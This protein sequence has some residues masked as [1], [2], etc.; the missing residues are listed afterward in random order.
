MGDELNRLIDQF[1][2]WIPKLLGAIFVLIIGWLIALVLK[3]ITTNALKRI[4]LNRRLKDL[5]S[6]HT[7]N[8][9]IPDPAAAVGGFIYWL[10]LIITITIMIGVLN[11]PVL[12]DLVN[13]IYSY[14]PNLLAAIVILILSIALSAFVSGVINRWMGD[15]PT[16]K[17]ISTIVLI[18][19]LSIS[20][21][22][23]LEQL[24]IA[25]AVV[26]ATYIAL[27]ST[28][29][30]AAALAFGLGGREVAAEILERAYDKSKRS[31]GQVRSDLEV[32][33]ERAQDDVNRTR[34]KYKK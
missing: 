31:M 15:T 34:R 9:I 14:V 8:R 30:L 26:L 22:A 19:I 21:F 3:N 25:P 1:I 5:P 16:G 24:R 2:N 27:L 18:V 17:A 29:S 13:G 4:G 33:K 7:L 23:I 32:G 12:T 10:I 6:D 11:I 20:G 28:I